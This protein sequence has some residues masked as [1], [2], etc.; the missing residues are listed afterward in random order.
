MIANNLR[1]R[2]PATWFLIFFVTISS[3]QMKDHAKIELTD[4]VFKRED[5]LSFINANFI[6]YTPIEW[7][8][9]FEQYN[10]SIGIMKINFITN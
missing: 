5:V 6:H 9:R 2:I 10:D 8:K 4:I 3:A 7:S 1:R